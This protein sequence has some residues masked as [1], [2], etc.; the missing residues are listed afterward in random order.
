MDT[1]E[2]YAALNALDVPFVKRDNTGKFIGLREGSETLPIVSSEVNP[3]NGGVGFSSDESGPL[4]PEGDVTA[5]TDGAGN[6]TGDYFWK[7]TFKTASGGETDANTASSIALSCSGNAVQLS[8]IPVSSD[9]SVIAR[10]IYRNSASLSPATQREG[11]Q[12]VATINDNTT[13]TYFDNVPDASLGKFV[14]R[15]SAF[16]PARY[17]RGIRYQGGGIISTSFGYNAM[18]EGTGYACTAVGAQSMPEVKG[19]RN[20]AIG[21]FSGYSLTLGRYN[22]AIGV[23]ALNFSALAES[24]TAVG[25]GAIFSN[26]G[27]GINTALGASSLYSFNSPTGGGNTVVGYCSG[28]SLTTGENNTGVGHDALQSCTTGT[29]NTGVGFNALKNSNGNFNTAVGFNSAPSV[30]GGFNV[31]MGWGALSASAGDRNIAIGPYAGNY[32]NSSNEVWIDNI[33]RGNLAASKSSS[34]IYGKTAANPK[35]QTLS[36]NAVIFPVQA[37]TASAPPYVK[38]GIYFDTTLNKLR[39]GGASGW[40]TVTSA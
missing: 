37:A 19:D 12:L 28:Y 17:K 29:Q 21:V 8:N 15:I 1:G 34:L 27:R 36:V 23:H 38:G 16:S 22:T 31:A 7:V 26:T 2:L 11:L 35:D 30:T 13:T 6:L 5:V 3:L 4:A 24:N 33:D 9:A 20:T 10:C 14:P 39:V 18:A 25:Y 32:A 40:E